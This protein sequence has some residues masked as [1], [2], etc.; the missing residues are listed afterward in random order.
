MD[1]AHNPISLK[2]LRAINLNDARGIET[3]S[4]AHGLDY[5]NV[6][7]STKSHHVASCFQLGRFQPSAIFP[8]SRV[9]HA[10]VKPI[11]AAIFS[12]FTF[13]FQ[14]SPSLYDIWH[15]YTVRLPNKHNSLG[16]VPVW[17]QPQNEQM[18]PSAFHRSFFLFIR[19]VWVAA[20]S[21]EGYSHNGQRH[22]R[23]SF[24]GLNT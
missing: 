20:T 5:N 15:L 18:R 1:G 7:S 9:L 8:Y 11:R 24:L 6:V 3:L 16:P 13:V 17:I 23:Y 14:S 10:K 21:A 12:A 19:L 4:R 22:A 2:R